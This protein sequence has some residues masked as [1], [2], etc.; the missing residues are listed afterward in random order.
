[1]A[2]DER[3]H[4]QQIRDVCAG[5]EQHEYGDGNPDAKRRQQILRA[6]ERPSPEWQQ[7]H[8]TPA[9]LVGIS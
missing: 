5:D 7:A 1:M 9:V 8:T 6:V 4:E 2:A 3:A